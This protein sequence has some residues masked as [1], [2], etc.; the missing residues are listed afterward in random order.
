MYLSRGINPVI[1]CFWARRFRPATK[2]LLDDPCGRTAFQENSNRQLATAQ[3]ILRQRARRIGP[4]VGGFVNDE[5][6]EVNIMMKK[7]DWAHTVIKSCL[8][9]NGNSNPN[10]LKRY[11][12][13]L[14]W[15]STALTLQTQ[16]AIG[17][18]QKLWETLKQKNTFPVNTNGKRLA[19]KHHQTLFGDQLFYRLVTSFGAVWSCLIKFEGHQ[20]FDQRT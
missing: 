5:N 11:N 13:W 16:P 20:T 10:N 17:K 6:R 19:T 8:C 18:R 1:Y 2:Q 4:G 3:N 15:R 9:H 14:G 12:D 7:V